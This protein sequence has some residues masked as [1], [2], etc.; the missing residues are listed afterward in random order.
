M[1]TGHTHIILPTYPLPL[2][3]QYTTLSVHL[4]FAHC[5]WI[6][7]SSS[8]THPY[9]LKEIPVIPSVTPFSTPA[10]TPPPLS[11]LYEPLLCTIYTYH[12]LNPT[13]A[14]LFIPNTCC[15][16]HPLLPV[17]PSG[18]QHMGSLSSIL[19]TL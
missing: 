13:Y 9:L 11:N 10:Y 4:Q 12:A 3:L 14:S 16:L 18:I 2:Y 15:P 8:S 6:S 7:S 1:A 5:L 17:Y 19:T